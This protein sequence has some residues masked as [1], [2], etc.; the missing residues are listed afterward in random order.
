MFTQ[1]SPLAAP[2]GATLLPDVGQVQG[3]VFLPAK[4]Q[5]ESWVI[6]Q[7]TDHKGKWNQLNLPFL[8]AMCLLELLKAVQAD[9]IRKNIPK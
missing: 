2:P 6:A 9:A 5:K 3:T 8:D 7:Y 4:T 1:P